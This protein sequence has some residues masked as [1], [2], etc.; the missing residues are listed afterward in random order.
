MEIRRSESGLS[1]VEIL[2]AVVLVGVV[3]VALLRSITQAID[4]Q[5]SA[6]LAST[7]SNLALESIELYRCY[8]NAHEYN[9]LINRTSEDVGDDAFSRSI[10]VTPTG[11]EPNRTWTISVTVTYQVRGSSRSVTHQTLFAER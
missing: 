3:I 2:I 6:E 8:F 9:K 7:A 11:T 10:D 5:K 1:L 4:V